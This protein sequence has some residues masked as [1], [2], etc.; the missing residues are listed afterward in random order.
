MGKVHTVFDVRSAF[1][2]LQL[3]EDSRNYTA[4]LYNGSG[5]FCGVYRYR[6]LN[7]GGSQSPKL[8]CN[9]VSDALRH[10]FK[11]M[12]MKIHI[13]DGLLSSATMEQHEIDVAKFLHAAFKIDLALD[14]SKCKF[15]VS[16]VDWCSLRFE[17]GTMRP[18]PDRL[19]CL[20]GLT[21]PQICKYKPGHKA[22]LRCRGLLNY[23]RK[24]C[25]KF[26]Q[27]M[28]ENADYVLDAWDSNSKLSFSEAQDK[29]NKNVAIVTSN[30]CNNALVV[31]PEGE[32]LNIF[33]DASSISYSFVLTRASDR[34]PVMFGGKSFNKVQRSYG[35][36]DRELL[37]VRLAMDS[38]ACFISTA[39]L[40][41]IH[42]DNLTSVL[43]FAGAHNE[44]TARSLRLLL[45]IKARC[46]P[47]VKFQFIE[48]VKN[49]VAD[50]LSRLAFHEENI[51]SQPE[52]DDC[53]KVQ[54]SHVDSKSSQNTKNIFENCNNE[55][56]VLTTRAQAL[57]KRRLRLIHSETH[58]GWNKL[59]ATA[60]DLKLAGSGLRDLCIEVCDECESCYNEKRLLADKFFGQTDT[61]SAPMREVSV[62]HVFFPE[63]TSGN[64]HALTIMDTW[65]KFFIAV[66]VPAL[67][68]DYVLN[69][70]RCYLSIF[71]T[72][73]VLRA[74]LA[75][76]NSS[77][78]ELCDIFGIVLKFYASHNSRSSNVER[79]H[80][81][82]RE[83]IEAFLK[84]KG[85]ADHEWD[86]VSH[87]ACK[88][89]NSAVHL[90]TKHMPHELVF[91]SKPE[92]KG[93]PQALDDSVVKRRV[94]VT[95]NITAA[96]EKY[97]KK[98][99]IPR[100]EPGTVVTIRYGSRN[101]SKA[102]KATVTEDPGG[103]TLTVTR[104][105]KLPGCNTR[106]ATIRVSKRH[107]W[108]TR[109]VYDSVCH[110]QL[111]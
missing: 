103:L 6:S 32:K 86:Q 100:L 39:K 91:N 76:Q 35:S 78:N 74:D 89:V 55:Y 4:F 92:L 36:L 96:K 109:K 107:V 46:G 16:S 102:F 51:P 60:R 72:V 2:R 79:C 81:T 11:D 8:F 53:R 19:T 17:N 84:V 73:D 65:S 71:S 30:I 1:H 24:Y 98:H 28:A 80:S 54:F 95:K 22:Y 42:S 10:V 14:I 12:N 3:H 75:F 85:L 57:L 40:V 62:D 110:V 34:R 90:T 105:E 99:Q 68:M 43:Q 104:L 26:S 25:P 5:E 88:A 50:A 33:T 13:D 67:T 108:V 97:S 7:Q 47:Q 87:L 77:I 111:F 52:G 56:V 93:L 106:Y 59:L 44:I 23:F 70:L 27:Y 37:A 9:A 64:A 94:E 63:S 66:P 83:K 45:E 49:V 101:K 21:W 41:T 31:V 69:A 38:A 20:Q 61:Q 82:Y 29:C 58:C 18:S 15:A 48:G